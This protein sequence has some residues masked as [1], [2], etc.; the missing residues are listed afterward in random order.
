MTRMITVSEGEWDKLEV[1]NRHLR[2]IIYNIC[3][4]SEEKLIG[5][6]K[7]MQRLATAQTIQCDHYGKVKV[8]DSGL[9]CGK[10][11]IR[12]KDAAEQGQDDA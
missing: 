12:L 8:S 2:G 3:G 11:G 1:E 10:C 7:K 5:H 9:H 4:M 6:L